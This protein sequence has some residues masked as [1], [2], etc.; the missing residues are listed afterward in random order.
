[1]KSMTGF[2]HGRTE[3]DD[4]SISI[5]FKSFNHRFLDTNFKGTGITPRT[6]KLIKEII[7]DKV[8]RGKVEIIF[9]LRV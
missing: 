1:M 5:S 3:L 2:A 7:K 4:I 9:K 8:C 6:E